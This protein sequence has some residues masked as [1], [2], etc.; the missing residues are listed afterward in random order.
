MIEAIRHTGI[1]VNNLD[2]Q[3]SFYRVLGFSKLSRRLETGPFIDQLT[4]I[5]SVK[6]EWAKMK[7]PDG[8]VLELLKYHSHSLPIP[9]PKATSNQ[10]G[11]SHIALTVTEINEICR[12][13]ETSGGSVVN[14]PALSPDGN[15]KV[16]YC[17][18]PEG[19]LIEVVEELI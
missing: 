1:V 16:A 6:V 19:V 13:I 3:I 15:V 11:C 14:S 2:R 8:S 7:A 18:D 17:H 5:N 10:M 4:G 9:Q 12:A